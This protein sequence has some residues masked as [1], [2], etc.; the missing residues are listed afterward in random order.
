MYRNLNLPAPFK[1]MNLRR[2]ILR[3]QD[4]HPDA[5]QIIDGCITMFRKAGLLPT[6]ET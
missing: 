2:E 3:A 6:P 5:D 1:G 4:F